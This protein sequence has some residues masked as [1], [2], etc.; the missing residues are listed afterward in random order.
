MIVMVVLII[1]IV[2]L[3]VLTIIALEMEVF[4]SNSSI[5]INLK[6]PAVENESLTSAL[7]CRPVVL[8]CKLANPSPIDSSSGF[9]V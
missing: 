3:V 9:R 6:A 5:N 8:V 4:Q 7:F 1:V 2:V